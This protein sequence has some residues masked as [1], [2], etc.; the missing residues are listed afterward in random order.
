ME[1][2]MRIANEFE[3]CLTFINCNLQTPH[4]Y[5]A[6]LVQGVPRMSVTLSRQTG[7]GASAV[8][9]KLA[10]FL[11]S[12]YPEKCPWTVFD[13][14]LM[15]QV[16]DEHHLPK[17]MAEFLPEDR[18]SA[19]DD[20]MEEL[21]GLH[22]SASTVV[23]QVTETIL[24]LV[25]LGHVILMGRGANAI[26]AK[27]PQVVHVRVV[28][29][30]EA[31]TDRVRRLRHCDAKSAAGF[32]KR[33]DQGRARYLQRYFHRD[34]DD[35]LLYD[36]VINTDRIALDSA[37]RLIGETVLARAQGLQQSDHTAAPVPA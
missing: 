20:M 37:A 7:S 28:G 6:H 18:T 1:E 5:R 9:E 34:I 33:S 14:N 29:S 11:Q 36:L 3:R 22:P 23:Y 30:M 12:H 24:H 19:I 31:R 4:G 26:T 2:D 15:E 13:K 21:L 10:G 25:E 16:M 27:L 35:P 32:I 17:R 8:A